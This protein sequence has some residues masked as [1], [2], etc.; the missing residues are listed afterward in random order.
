MNEPHSF[1]TPEP[2][3]LDVRNPAGSV[4]VT[5]AETATSTVEIRPRSERPD[6]R[7]RAERV[8]VELSADG[9]RLTVAVPE[10]RAVFGRGTAALDIRVTVPT[11][12][13]LALHTASAEVSA[14]GRFAA[15]DARTA[16]GG[17][18]VEEVTGPADVYAASGG[19]RIGAAG[20]LDVR[21]ASGDIRL[22]HA[23]GDTD[24]HT[25]SGSITI[26][27]ADASVRARTASGDVEI[28]EVSD[29][30]VDAHT[31]SGNVRVGVRAGVAVRLDLSTA[32]GRAR[33]ELPVE[34]APPP[35]GA[36]LHVRARAASGNVLVTRA[37]GTGVG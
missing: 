10:R 23:T 13:Q 27:V 11:G 31:A 24:A 33:S 21:T 17:I 3:H 2:V 29:G 19:V 6:A 37:A 9:R 15:L 12:S 34:D 7:E 14:R 32:S 1:A 22:A 5:A 18:A 16:S 35:G 30:R 8:A 36:T 26:G 25:A 28:G 4:E 20:T